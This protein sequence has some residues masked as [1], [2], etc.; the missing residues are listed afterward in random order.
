MLASQKIWAW[1]GDALGTVRKTT[2]RGRKVYLSQGDSLLS[3]AITFVPLVG[4]R[5]LSCFLP[6][7]SNLE[8]AMKVPVTLANTIGAAFLGVAISCM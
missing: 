1:P 6:R 4:H 3:V 8:P 5:R 2:T 7:C